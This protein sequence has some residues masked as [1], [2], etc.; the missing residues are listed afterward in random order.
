MQDLND[1]W[2]KPVSSPPQRGKGALK[3]MSIKGREHFCI[4][5]CCSM[6]MDLKTSSTWVSDSPSKSSAAAS[7]T[8]GKQGNTGIT[9]IRAWNSF[10][11]RSNPKLYIHLL[12]GKEVTSWSAWLSSQ[13]LFKWNDQRLKQCLPR[14]Q[15]HLQPAPPLETTFSLAASCNSME[16]GTHR[17]A[18]SHSAARVQVTIHAKSR[19][20]CHMPVQE[21]QRLFV[22][23]YKLGD[24][25]KIN[26]LRKN[27]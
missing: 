10:Q 23:V 17:N 13:A 26:C 3:R 25:Q 4:N 9:H 19:H 11:K 7:K 14:H 27:T 20:Y 6:T 12:R 15:L 16:P 21:A 18:A 2:Q 1:F 8:C 5:F 24:T 22:P